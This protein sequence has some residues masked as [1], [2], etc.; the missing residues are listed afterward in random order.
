MAVSARLSLVLLVASSL[1]C[2]H[3]Q[4][5]WITPV[6]DA[7]RPRVPYL[8]FAGSKVTGFTDTDGKS[9]QP[10]REVSSG[11]IGWTTI[12]DEAAC[13]HDTQFEGMGPAVLELRWTGDVPADG[14]Y[15]LDTFK[16]TV[17][18]LGAVVVRGSWNG[19]A[20]AVASLI[21]EVRSPHCSLSWSTPLAAEASS[22]PWMRAREFHGYKEIPPLFLTGCRA[23]E[24]LDVRVR[25][26][27]KTNRGRIDVESFGF[28]PWSDQDAR[29]LF[30]LV[31]KAEGEVSKLKLGPCH[32]FIGD[33]CNEPNFGPVQ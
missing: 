18:T 11:L 19:D 33:F 14:N 21:V 3:A 25:L 31:R 32:H 16:Y 27:A 8:G 5:T 7:D 1:A 24:M 22:G 20:I 2:A 17:K 26:F 13:S 10:V 28:E 29:R 9:C 12:G 6:H 15:E 23:G 4:D 30:G